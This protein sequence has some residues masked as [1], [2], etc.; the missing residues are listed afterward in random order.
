[1][2]IAKN[3]IIPTFIKILIHKRGMKKKTLVAILIFS[4]VS[5]SNKK[6]SLDHKGSAFTVAKEFYLKP[7]I[8][9]PDELDL[10]Y[11]MSRTEYSPNDSIYFVHIKATTKNGFGVKVPVTFFCYLK[12]IGSNEDDDLEIKNWKYIDSSVE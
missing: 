1:M 8:K 4:I 6:D 5:C 11:S 10:D 3:G 9:Y 7:N 2:G 12:Y